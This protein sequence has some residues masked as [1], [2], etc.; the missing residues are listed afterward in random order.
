MWNNF[1]TW[2]LNKFF[3]F[4]F[5][6]IYT[7][8]REYMLILG[9]YVKFN[10][11][12]FIYI[13][14]FNSRSCLENP[15]KITNTAIVYFM[16]EKM[17]WNKQFSSL[18]FLEKLRKNNKVQNF[19]SICTHVIYSFHLI[20][21]RIVNALQMKTINEMLMSVWGWVELEIGSARAFWPFPEYINEIP[22]E[23]FSIIANTKVNLPWKSQF[24][25]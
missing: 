12:L 5:Y 3:L 23:S 21:V 2:S 25:S 13:S 16:L 8:T 22:N 4:H 15:P 14:I 18:L 1:A 20:V 9:Y 11:S 17:W 6:S 7:S 10:K 24:K 19:L